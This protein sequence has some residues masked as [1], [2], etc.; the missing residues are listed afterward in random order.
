MKNLIH[1]IWIEPEENI[2]YSIKTKKVIMKKIYS[3]TDIISP[4]RAE[5][6]NWMIISPIINN[7]F[8]KTIL[9]KSD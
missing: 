7:F 6:P 2:F 8:M 5:S 3:M 4:S 9:M 1:E